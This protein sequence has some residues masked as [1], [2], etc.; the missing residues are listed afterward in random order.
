MEAIRER[1]LGELSRL[2]RHPTRI[3]FYSTVTGRALDEAALDG[4]YWYRNLRR[5][6]QFEQAVRRRRPAVWRR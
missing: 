6:G 1:M 5:D 4:E 3:P 2:D